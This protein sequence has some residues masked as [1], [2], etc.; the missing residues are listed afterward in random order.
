[1][2]CCSLHNENFITCECMVGLVVNFEFLLEIKNNA[3]SDYYISYTLASYSYH[4]VLT[5]FLMS[6]KYN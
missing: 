4:I 1:M 3:L 2:L 6:D 5:N